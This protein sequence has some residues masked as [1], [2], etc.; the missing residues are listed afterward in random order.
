MG[1]IE[2]GRLPALLDLGERQARGIAAQLS[3][4]GLLEASTHRAPLRLAFPITATERWFPNLYP[5]L[6]R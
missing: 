2:R 1:E 3:G 4:A 5:S 6:E